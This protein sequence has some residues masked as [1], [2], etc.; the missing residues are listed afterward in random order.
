[1][2]WGVPIL[3]APEGRRDE[4]VEPC[5]ERALPDAVVV[6]LKAREPARILVSIGNKQENR[7]HLELKHRWVEQYSFYIKDARWGRMLVRVCPY[8]PFSARVCLNRHYWLPTQMRARG[9][10]DGRRSE[11]P[12]P[13]KLRDLSATR[14]H[15]GRGHLVIELKARARVSGISHAPGVAPDAGRGRP[16][17]RRLGF[18]PRRD[19]PRMPFVATMPSAV[20]RETVRLTRVL[21]SPLESVGELCAGCVIST[22]V[23]MRWSHLGDAARA[24]SPEQVEVMV[25][26]I[27]RPRA[28]PLPHGFRSFDTESRG[29]KEH[30][31]DRNGWWRGGAHGTAGWAADHGRQDTSAASEVLEFRLQLISQLHDGL[32]REIRPPPATQQRHKLRVPDLAALSRRHSSLP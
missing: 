10:R 1:M 21:A 13:S 28:F 25:G 30:G 18:S 15:P 32:P 24:R 26:T 29:P 12:P 6:I 31:P 7:W 2:K 20:T 27:P 5:F 19:R 14:D 8:F 11:D 3:D 23:L 17:S 16:G 4:F 22:F 9:L